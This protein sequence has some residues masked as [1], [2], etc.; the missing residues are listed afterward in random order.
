MAL[1]GG[2]AAGVFAETRDDAQNFDQGVKA[3][4]A[5]EKVRAGASSLDEPKAARQTGALWISLAAEDMPKIEQAKLPLGPAVMT[6]DRASVFRVEESALPALSAFMHEEFGR[7]G[8]FFAHDSSEEAQADLGPAPAVMAGPFTVDQ[9]AFTAPAV[10]KVREGELRATIEKLTSFHNRYYSAESGVAAAKWI[11]GRWQELASSIPG[12]T[13][14]LV[15]H[16]GWKQASVVLTIPGSEKPEEIV[17][18]GGHLD[19]INGMWGGEANRAPG[20]DDNASGIAVLTESLRVLAASGFRPRR[21]VEF[22]GYAAE[23]VGLRGSKEIAASYSKQGKKVAAV[24]QF[25]MTN[26]KGSD[27]AIYLLTDH[28]DP[29]V[30]DFLGKLIDAYAQVP[31]STT[32]CGYACSDHASW[33]RSGYPSSAAF[34][35]AFDGMNRDIHTDRDTLSKSGGTAEHSVSFAKLAAA[36]AAEVAKVA[37]PAAA[38]SAR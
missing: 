3:S 9:Q 25:D 32:K 26:Y 19:S 28:V 27:K 29:G 4:A 36:F 13:A 31:W 18:L 17:V 10:A 33:T 23:E 24:I 22:M 2:A 15:Q 21:T 30:T 38:R 6:G 11:Q 1:L 8:G 20:A 37:A 7:C 34:E 35:S 16:P 14:R 12:A 5:L